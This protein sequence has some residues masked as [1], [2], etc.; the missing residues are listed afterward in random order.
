MPKSTAGNAERQGLQGSPGS[1]APD[2][3]QGGLRRADN[4]RHR[5]RNRVCPRTIYLYFE[6][7]DASRFELCQEFLDALKPATSIA[8]PV[9]RLRELGRRY[10][11]FGLENPKTYHLIFM[12]DPKFDE[13]PVST[14]RRVRDHLAR[15]AS[16]SQATPIQKGSPR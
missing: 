4:A 1:S 16:F 5:R 7:R 14:V 3:A 2:H 8:Y 6:S 13:V 12:D 10:V 15:V 9:E 11:Q